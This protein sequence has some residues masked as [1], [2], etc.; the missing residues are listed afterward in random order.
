MNQTKFIY[1]ALQWMI[2]AVILYIG[3]GCGQQYYTPN[4]VHQPMLT[5]KGE[6]RLSGGLALGDQTQGIDIQTAYAV[7]NKIGLM[8]NGFIT[9]ADGK[10]DKRGG[11][12]VEA[13]V[14][15]YKK[16]GKWGYADVYGGLGRGQVNNLI[17]NDTLGN[18]ISQSGIGFVRAFVQPSIGIHTTYFDM[19]FAVRCVGMRYSTFTRPEAPNYYNFVEYYSISQRGFIGYEPAIMLRGGFKRIQ[20]QSQL[21]LSYI[22]LP[23]PYG[24]FNFQLGASIPLH[25]EAKK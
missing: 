13:G 11:W 20:F 1:T 17:V 5:Q 23:V 24:K 12:L 10:Y 9:N 21:G 2:C 6:A 7:S 14:G 22:N 18:F 16:L 15:R 3:W 19:G 25:F 8:V 4:A